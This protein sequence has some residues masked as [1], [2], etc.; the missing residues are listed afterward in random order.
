M[1]L[2]R[3]LFSG[4]SDETLNRLFDVLRDHV[5]DIQD[6]GDID[7]QGKIISRMLRERRLVKLLPRVAADHLKAVFA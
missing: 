6:M 3:K 1:G 2:A 5:G 7:F 4:L